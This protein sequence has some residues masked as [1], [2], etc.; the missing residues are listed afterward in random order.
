MLCMQIRVRAR[1]GS[2]WKRA[3]LQRQP[4][5]SLLKE[6]ACKAHSGQKSMT[7]GAGVLDKGSAVD[8]EAAHHPAPGR[9]VNTLQ[10]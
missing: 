4:L 3:G 10:V 8:Q 7:S 1:R 2:Q 5:S 9:Q 6:V